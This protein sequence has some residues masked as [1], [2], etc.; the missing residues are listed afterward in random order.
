MSYF[1]KQC[2]FFLY[3]NRGSYLESNSFYTLVYISAKDE[4]EPMGTLAKFNG[5]RFIQYK[6]H[7]AY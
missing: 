5:K 2:T 4:R 3:L 1:E 6:L 7:N